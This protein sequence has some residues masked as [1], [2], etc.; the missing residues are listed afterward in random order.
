MEIFTQKA[1]SGLPE[2]LFFISFTRESAYV[3]GF[4]KQKNM[5]CES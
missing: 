3:S 5:A 1:S 2:R 4:L